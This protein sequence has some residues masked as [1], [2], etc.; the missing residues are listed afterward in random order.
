MH[1]ICSHSSN[2]R[3][4]RDLQSAAG[5]RAASP[6][7]IRFIFSGLLI[8][9]TSSQ[10]TNHAPNM[11]KLLYIQMSVGEIWHLLELKH[12]RERNLKYKLD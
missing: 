1:K 4:I 11:L 9:I 5:L 2:L 6:W 12:L 7:V 8:N 10:G 3:L